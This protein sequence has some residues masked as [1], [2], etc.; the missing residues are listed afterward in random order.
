MQL[1]NRF[2]NDEAGFV[3]S[4]ELILIATILVIAMLTGLV[5]VRDAVVQELGDIGNAIG[6]ISQS[7][8]YSGVT[9]HNSSVSGAVFADLRDFC[10]NP[11]LPPSA[12]TEPQCMNVQ[13]PAGTGGG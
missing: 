2:W 9:S 4:S 3:V 5:T 12:G 7:Y 1:I 6:R 10:E 11:S 13:Q 8:S